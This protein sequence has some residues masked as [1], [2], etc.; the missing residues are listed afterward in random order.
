MIDART[1]NWR[2]VVPECPDRLLLLPVAGESV[3][4]ATMCATSAGE[5][6]AAL[7]EGPYGAVVAPDLTAWAARNHRPVRPLLEALGSALEPG[8]WLYVGFRAVPSGATGRRLSHAAATRTLRDSGL[9]TEE[10]YFALPSPACAAYLIPS[11][12]TAELD[13]FLRTVFFPYAA[14]DSAWRGRLRQV[15]LA[16]GRRAALSAPGWLRLRLAPA[17]GLVAGR[18]S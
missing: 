6:A 3:P 13:H 16:A 18:A 4:E 15:A 5:L 8:G 7:R 12:R 11:T 17:F 14:S 10:V 9:E 2:F 1:L